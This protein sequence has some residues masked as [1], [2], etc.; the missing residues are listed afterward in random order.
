M[1]LIFKWTSFEE[2]NEMKI[3]M[4]MKK[5]IVYCWVRNRQTELDDI[6]VT[7]TVYADSAEAALIRAKE[8]EPRGYEFEVYGNIDVADIIEIEGVK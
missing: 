2:E 4:E 7:F 5:F 8:L 6:R 1:V 3:E